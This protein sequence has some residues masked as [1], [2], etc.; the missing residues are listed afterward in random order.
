MISRIAIAAAVTA[1]C[2]S[3][4][5]LAAEERPCAEQFSLE[6]HLIL[7]WAALG[8]DPEAQ[9]SLSQCAYPAGAT[10]LST[11]QKVYALKW[12]T[13]AACDSSPNAR[14][15]PM[16]RALKYEGNI[17]FRRFG[18][19]SEE[20][21]WTA[22]ERKLIE[23]RKA[24][25]ADLGARLAR[26]KSEATPDEIVAARDQLA[27]QFARMGATGLLRLT[28]M[29]TCTEFGASPSFA[30]A[31]WSAA[32]DT[33]SRPE[34]TSVYGASVQSDFDLKRE[35]DKRAAALDRVDRRR[36]AMEKDALMQADPARLAALEDAA[37][38]GRLEK[39]GFA[40]A[41]EEGFAFSGRAT[42]TAIQY[43]LEALGF[44]EF[45]NGPDNDYGPSTIE[46]A[47]KAQAAYGRPQ[48]R[49]LAPE[50]IRQVVCDA[51]V[52][53]ADPVSF[54]HL[55]MM[56]AEGMGFKKDIGL[57]RIAIAK[58]EENMSARLMHESAL[59]DWKR[60]AYPDYA[61]KISAAKKSIDASFAALPAHVQARS[62]GADALCR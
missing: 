46:A 27:D 37:A 30:A 25:V 54:Y 29:T 11:P 6:E 1:A 58:A 40:S 21:T 55:G 53:K 42:T 43:A 7:E 51:A 60:R 39:L 13:L 48:T 8:G 59:P 62:T 44:I 52:K 17:S 31:A 33:W 9:Y 12:L 16:T 45:V 49:F 22:R 28:D 24:Q 14:R 61:E 20:E 2:F 38:L 3:G 57:A 47:R 18:A 23:V 19:I 56:Y 34:N 4:A 41:S 10:S 35:A 36:M 50:E 26:L 5:A 15:D 32:A